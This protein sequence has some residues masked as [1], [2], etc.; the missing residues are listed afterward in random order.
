MIVAGDEVEVA[1]EH[2]RRRPR[3]AG[4]RAAAGIRRR[5][6]MIG[7]GFRLQLA[8]AIDLAFVLAKTGEQDR[9]DYL[10]NRSLAFIQGMFRHG[11][12]GYGIADV[13]IFAL[14]GKSEAALTTLRQAIEEGWRQ[15]W[16]YYAEHD[17][18]LDSIRYELEFQIMMEEIRANMAEQLAR[19]HE[20]EANG[21]L[22]PIS[23]S[24]E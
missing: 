19:V 2:Q 21:E 24:L 12:K 10:L 23:K 14:Q 18:N 13:Q 17:P 11:V 4:E 8:Q 20:W 22:A 3:G 6:S 7:R 1:A 16:W 9:A 15:F 5:R